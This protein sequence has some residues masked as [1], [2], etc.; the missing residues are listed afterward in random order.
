MSVEVLSL[1]VKASYTD[2]SYIDILHHTTTVK[3]ASTT[4]LQRHGYSRYIH[5]LWSLG[6]IPSMLCS[7][8]LYGALYT[9]AEYM[10]FECGQIT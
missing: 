3:S 10:H 1:M 2:V 5:F 7:S 4:E 9:D 8:F 6:M